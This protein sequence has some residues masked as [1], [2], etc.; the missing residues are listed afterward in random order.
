MRGKFEINCDHYPSERSKL[1]HKENWVG[2][3]I[4]Q[5]LEPC[6]RLNSIT[7]FTTID[8]LFNYL[9]DIFG[10]SHQKKHAMEKFRE[11]KMGTSLL[12]DFYSEFIQLA[13][14]PKYTLEMLIRKFKHKLTSQLQDW[15]NSS[16]ELP[17]TIS[18]LVKRCLS[19]YE[20]MQATNRIRKKAKF[21]T[22][23]WTT[24]IIPLR[25][26]ISSSRAPTVSNNNISFS[27]LSNTFQRTITLTPWNLD[28][29]ISRLIKEEICFNCKRR[30]NTMLNCPKKTK[31]SAI[32]DASH[33]DNIENIDQEEE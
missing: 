14:D 27:C 19:I 23:V 20:Q 30:G 22:I 10:D 28:A 15:L 21:S 5:Y 18:A 1:I 2:G 16:I 7:S 3:K 8:K 26:V 17:N 4:L 11:L 31:I 12:S 6:L 25:A 29:E 33:I 24:A 32:T 13:S 9:K